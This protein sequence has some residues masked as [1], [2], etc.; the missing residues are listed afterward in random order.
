M[1]RGSLHR[2]TPSIATMLVGV[3]AFAVASLAASDASAKTCTPG[4]SPA[5]KLA[6]VIANGD[7]EA[8]S[9]VTDLGGAR[10]DGPLIR[11]SL[12]ARGFT[13]S[14]YSDL[15]ERNFQRALDKFGRSL[16]CQD[17]AIIYFAGHGFQ[18]DG[19]NYLVPTDVD[20]SSERMI[21]KTAVQ[22]SDLYEVLTTDSSDALRFVILDACRNNPFKDQRS[23]GGRGFKASSADG[24]VIWYSTGSGTTA[25][26]RIDASKNSNSPFAY[27]FSKVL[28]DKTSCGDGLDEVRKSINR[29]MKT[30]LG[31]NQVPYVSSSSLS[32]FRFCA[33]T[34]KGSA[35]VA[36]KTSPTSAHDGP[37][38]LI[39]G[40]TRYRNKAHDI[41]FYMPPGWKKIT[42]DRP[43]ALVFEH[44][45]KA[46]I[47]I[48]RSMIE[49]PDSKSHQRYSKAFR[50]TLLEANFKLISERQSTF[51]SHKGLKSTYS[52]VHEGTSLRVITVEF[53]DGANVL[54]AV[55]YVPGKV[56]S[57]VAVSSFEQVLKTLE[58]K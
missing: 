30:N 53:F 33:A 58:W 34:P 46:V 3:L 9:G 14:F 15:D 13:V 32:D 57:D 27:A 49:N 12:R 28:A 6:L 2:F 4:D 50:K 41:A 18:V 40:S 56:L 5:R 51:G 43:G 1:A 17:H 47:D 16:R 44:S 37:S 7:Y 48:R 35:K 26:D 19:V 24:L 23:T 20:A 42:S 36:S 11:D 31:V 52:F 29:Y 25:A 21:K 22:A 10:A 39:P 45:S 38:W 8:S 55:L 54:T